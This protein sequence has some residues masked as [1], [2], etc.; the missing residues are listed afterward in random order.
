MVIFHPHKQLLLNKQTLPPT[1]ISRV[2]SAS[3]PVVFEEE[4]SQVEKK[5]RQKGREAVTEE[6]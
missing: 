4:R 1:P 5:V 6:T 2:V 3:S